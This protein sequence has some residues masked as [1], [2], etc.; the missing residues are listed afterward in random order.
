MIVLKICI[1]TSALTL[2]GFTVKFHYLAPTPTK[3]PSLLL[4]MKKPET[5]FV[6]CSWLHFD[7]AMS[8]IVQHCTVQQ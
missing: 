4:T 5:D 3:L 2:K 6:P 7:I 1:V 8:F